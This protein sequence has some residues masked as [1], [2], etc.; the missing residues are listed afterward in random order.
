MYVNIVRWCHDP[1]RSSSATIFQGLKQLTAMPVSYGIQIFH[2]LHSNLL[3]VDDH[4]E[5]SLRP[6]ARIQSIA[7]RTYGATLFIDTY[8]TALFIDYTAPNLVT[9]KIL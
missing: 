4:A 8:E 6:T 1:T 9:F 5:N 2:K 3:G 7:K